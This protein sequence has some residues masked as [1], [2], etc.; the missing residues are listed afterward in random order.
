[1]ITDAFRATVSLRITVGDDTLSVDT[2]VQLDSVRVSESP[3]RSVRFENDSLYFV[4]TIS[5]AEVSFAGVRVADTYKGAVV[6]RR[7]AEVIANG[8]FTMMRQPADSPV[9]FRSN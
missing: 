3:A 4:T 1:M 6:A 7:E 2:K 9:R 5:G 8:T